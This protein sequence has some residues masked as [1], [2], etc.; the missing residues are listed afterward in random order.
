MHSLC[1]HDIKRCCFHFFFL[2][3]SQDINDCTNTIC[4]NGGTCSDGVNTFTCNCSVGFTGDKCETSKVVFQCLL[5][6]RE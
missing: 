6:A 4:F 1:I 3:H 2:L 5:S